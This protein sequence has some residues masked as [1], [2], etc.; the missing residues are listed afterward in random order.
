MTQV[1]SDG[2]R[3]GVPG[4]L[5]PAPGLALLHSTRVPMTKPQARSTVPGLTVHSRH[6]QLNAK[7]HMPCARCTAKCFYKNWC[8]INF[9]TT[10]RFVLL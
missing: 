7:G 8:V 1:L 9:T 4:L 5:L 2:A 10:L 6:R 3:T